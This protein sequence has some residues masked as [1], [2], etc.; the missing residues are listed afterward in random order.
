MPNI[1]TIYM[2]TPADWIYNGFGCKC[3]C[4]CMVGCI[5]AIICC[6]CWCCCI[7]NNVKEYS[8]Y[9]CPYFYCCGIIDCLGI[10]LCGGK[11]RISNHNINNLPDVDWSEYRR[12]FHNIGWENVPTPPQEINRKDKQ[13]S[14]M[15]VRAIYNY[16]NNT[17]SK[18]RHGAEF[19][20]ALEKS[21]YVN[22]KCKSLIEKNRGKRPKRKR[23]IINS[24][25]C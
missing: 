18:I 25:C 15:I 2:T 22:V 6:P 4:Q 21:G 3:A 10:K 11:C 5:G 17:P 23:D 8:W 7:N 16:T 9:C 13:Y 19:L 14:D 20:K 24:D 12:M 1:D